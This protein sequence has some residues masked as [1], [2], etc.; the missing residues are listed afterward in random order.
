MI[1]KPSYIISIFI[2]C[3]CAIIQAQ[4]ANLKINPDSLNT[5]FLES[6]IKIKIDSVRLSN[7]KK[8]LAYN[9]TLKKAAVDQINYVKKKKQ[10]T[11]FQNDVKEKYDISDRVTY[12]GLQNTYVG[13][14]LAYTYIIMK[15]NNKKDGT[16]TNTTYKDLSDDIVKLWVKSKGHFKNILDE[17][18]TKTA[19]AVSY[20]KKTKIV[21]AG[22]VFSSE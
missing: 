9:D 5:C 20:D 7:N 17:E 10:L 6:L 19:V 8:T 3:N 14:N 21:Y 11:H 1:S 18:F 16:Y 15:I 12:Y 4:T 13:E 2:I 22:Q